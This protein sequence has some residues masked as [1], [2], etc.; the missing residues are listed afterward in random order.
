M[1]KGTLPVIQSVEEAK[2]VDHV[3]RLC[4][5]DPHLACPCA[6][7][8][9]VLLGWVLTN[10]KTG[11]QGGDLAGLKIAFQ[12]RNHDC[13]LQVLGHQPYA[14]GLVRDVYRVAAAS[15]DGQD[16]PFMTIS[17]MQFNEVQKYITN[18]R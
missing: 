17:A 9:L 13:Q 15:G 1:G 2:D 5:Y 11:D 7:R 18:I 4:A 14:H 12:E 16:N 8:G 6:Y 3:G 10:P